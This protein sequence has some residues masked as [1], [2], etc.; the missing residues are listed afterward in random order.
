MMK[1]AWTLISASLAD[2]NNTF[3][4]RYLA[5]TPS[6]ISS[7][8]LLCVYIIPFELNLGMTSVGL[9]SIVSQVGRRLCG[10][11]D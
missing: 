10:G 11:A 5:Q 4:M 6:S 7:A 3:F 9:V 1:L 2:E 8:D